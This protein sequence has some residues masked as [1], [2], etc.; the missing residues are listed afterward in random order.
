MSEDFVA[1]LPNFGILFGGFS[2][3]PQILP[4]LTL[5][6]RIKEKMTK[7]WQKNPKRFLHDDTEA[8]LNP[9]F[10]VCVPVPPLT[11]TYV[12]Y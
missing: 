12:I 7:I 10:W 9:R 8:K 1:F 4:A 5:V 3:V 2:K 11:Y 6:K